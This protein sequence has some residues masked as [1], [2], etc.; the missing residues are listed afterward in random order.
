MSVVTNPDTYNYDVTYHKLEF[1]VDP[2]E[3]N[4]SGKVTTT[5]TALENMSTIV[6]DLNSITDVIRIRI[7]PIRLS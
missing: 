3:Y 1:T 6:F 2:A 5:Y 7:S 4:I